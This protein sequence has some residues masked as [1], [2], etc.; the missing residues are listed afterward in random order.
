MQYTV[1]A[2]GDAERG[3]KRQEVVINAHNEED[4]WTKAWKAFPEY[5]ELLVT[6]KE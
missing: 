4:A 2:Y 5:K 6:R 1:I 3:L